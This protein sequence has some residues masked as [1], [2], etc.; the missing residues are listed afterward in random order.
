MASA[1]FYY[2]SSPNIKDIGL[3]F[4]VGDDREGPTN[5]G[6]VRTPEG[7][8]IVFSNEYQHKVAGIENSSTTPAVRKILAFFGTVVSEL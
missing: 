6:T 4:R 1:L 7:R 8:C 3:S 2:S 5:L